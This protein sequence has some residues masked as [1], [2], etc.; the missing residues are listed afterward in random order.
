MSGWDATTYEGKDTIMRVVRSEANRMFA[1]AE[2]PDRWEAP[3]ACAGWSTRDVVGHLVDTTEGYFAAF[4]AAR[5]H[6]DVG[7]AYGLP[8]MGERANAQATA[9][10]TATQQEMLDRLHADFEKMQGILEPLG[11]EDWTGLMVSHFYMG[12]VPAFF[13][14]AGQLMDYAVHSWDIREGTGRAHALNV[15]AADLLGPFMFGLWQGT[16]RPGADLTPFALGIRVSGGNNAGDFRVDVDENGM[17]YE[18]GSLDDLPTVIQFDPAGLV[19][20]TFGRCNTGTVIGDN[21]VA[22]RFLNLFY[23]I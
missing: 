17:R 18:Q 4:D 9:F 10:R 15:E 5:A 19:L 21:A 2:P 8:G 3:T 16:V 7:D 1:L 20:R 6:T 22:E 13:F 23:S 14:A 11:P 12:P